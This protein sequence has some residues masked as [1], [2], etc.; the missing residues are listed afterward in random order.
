MYV[1]AIKKNVIKVKQP[2]ITILNFDLFINVNVPYSTAAKKNEQGC[3][4]T[5]EGRRLKMNR[6]NINL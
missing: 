1:Q 2:L 4:L 5:D 6:R 3:E